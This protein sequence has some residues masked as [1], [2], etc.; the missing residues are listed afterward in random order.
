MLHYSDTVLKEW[1]QCMVN[2]FSGSSMNAIASSLECI[3][4]YQYRDYNR[5]KFVS[6]VL[7]LKLYKIRYTWVPHYII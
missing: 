4:K 6:I 2:N 3:N 7:C 1:I 5:P